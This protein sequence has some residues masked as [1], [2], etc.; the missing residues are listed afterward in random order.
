MDDKDKRIAELERLLAKAL[1]RI[2]ELE[3][4]LVL[5]SQTSSKPPSAD[6]LNKPSPKSLRVSL[7]SF[8]GQ[9][10]HKGK[11]LEQVA[12]PDQTVPLQILACDAC[13]TSLE[14]IPGQCPVKRQVFEVELNR[15][16]IEYQAEVKVC[17]CGKRNVAEFPAPVSR[18]V[19]YGSSIKGLG[20]YLMQHFVPKERCAEVFNEL[21]D[22]PLS[23]TTLM[24]FEEECAANLTPCYDSLREAL[25]KAPLKHLDESGL[26]VN[27]QL[28]WLHVLSNSRA[29]YYH[30]DPKRG[31]RWEGLEGT[32][33][34]D[35][36]KA[37]YAI[38]G[39]KHGL[40]NAHHL[41]ELNACAEVDQEPWAKMMIELLQ[42][43]LKGRNPEEISKRY[44]QLAQEGLAYH[45]SRLLANHSRR[46]N[47]RKRPGHNLLIRL[48]DYK[49]DTLRF[50]YEKG[51]PFTNNQAEQDIR[52]VK[53]K[54]KVSGCFR[55]ED[56]AKEFAK[57]RSFVST[58]R[59]QGMS[60]FEQL[61]LACTQPYTHT[62][63]SFA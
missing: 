14:S 9:K 63:L 59:K 3:R 30:V 13:H 50:M 40:C 47:G 48:M 37:Y 27:K 41:R 42:E 45:E 11:T 33:I 58:L 25:A 44:D 21:L 56:G 54:Q 22:V 31:Y 52:M 29:T 10:G 6:G 46:K 53:V 57:I 5:N 35:H 2:K 16:V 4:R 8:G 23:D 55:S 26:R 38:A 32:L 61:K 19:Q 1:A 24:A 34:H 39:V 15:H 18:P 12:H 51:V 7:K 20:V 36:W 60:L 62:N 43:A 49:E 28:Q 17:T